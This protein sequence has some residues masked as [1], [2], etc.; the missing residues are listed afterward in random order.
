MNALDR[1]RLRGLVQLLGDG[2]EHGSAAVE[3][4]HRQ[5]ARRPFE[6]VSAIPPLASGARVV[7]GVHDLVL[8]GVYGCVRAAARLLRDLARAGG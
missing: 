7:Q 3:E 2:V 5:T 4:I 6:I 8:T 1:E